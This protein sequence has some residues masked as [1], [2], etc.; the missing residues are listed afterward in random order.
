MDS[1]F[2]ENDKLPGFKR[3]SKVSRLI[4][5][6]CLVFGFSF[7][8]F[9][10]G[11]H[12][13][14]PIGNG[15]I[16][17]GPVGVHPSLGLTETYT[18]NVYRSYD[19]K[20]KESDFITTLSPGLQLI[21][22]LRRHSVK[23][24]YRADIN[25]FSS[26]SENDYVRQTATGGINLDFPGGLLLNISDTFID[27]EAMRRWKEQ[28]G[29]G[30]SADRYRAKPYQANDFVTKARYNF[31]GRWAAVAW[32][33]FYKNDYDH[34]YDRI[35]SYDRNLAGGSL[36]YR[37]TRKTDLLVEFQH[38]RVVYPHDKFHDN[39]NNTVY[40]GLGF[41]PGARL[42]GYLKAGWTG[43]KYDEKPGSLKDE[44]NEPSL[45]IDLRYNLS[46]SDVIEFRGMRIIEEDEDTN[47]PFTRS[48]FSIGYRHVMS[49]NRKIHP[50]V[51]IGCAKHD[52]DGFS[53]DVDGTVKQ[54]DETIYHAT[55]G[56]DYAMQ[57]WLMWKLGYTYRKRDSNFVRYD[58]NENRV[59]LNATVSF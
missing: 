50:N 30:G 35:N 44:F 20:E 41:D 17:L 24:G 19:G 21:L 36:L 27:S 11:V 58:Y 28:P 56:V 48:D 45:Q 37:F 51:R 14:A 10:A 12:S 47:E 6:I 4:L 7:M 15:N 55:V 59:F 32:Y 40:L 9:P 42:D 33:E 8:A 26:F 49:L 54:R 53:S 13:Q 31:A 22:P 5:I 57:R 18:D 46:P 25:R 2:H 29:L 43:K 34:E 52:Y 38:S 1:R 3:N 23:A 16:Q 39:K